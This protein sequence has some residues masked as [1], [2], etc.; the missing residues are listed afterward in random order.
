MS[1]SGVTAALFDFDGTLIDTMGEYANI[2]GDVLHRAYGIPKDKGSRL[3]LETS[4]IPFFQ[5]IELIVPGGEGNGE[6]V[7]AFETRKLEGFF[8]ADYLPDVPPALAALGKGGIKVILSSNNYQDLVERFVSE[9]RDVAFDL[10]LGCRENFFKGKDHFDEVTRRFGIEAA[11]MLFV[12][13]SFK[14]AERAI[15]SDV[16]FVAV[17]R[18]FSADD[19]RARY[20]R[21]HTVNDLSV[22]PDLLG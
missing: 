6:A 2:A 11:E 5:Q 3:Y 14:D 10:V 12:G 4:G 16:R 17:T 8:S 13:D 19:F 7:D 20:P 1:F 9:K 21:I 15:E 18:T 22:L